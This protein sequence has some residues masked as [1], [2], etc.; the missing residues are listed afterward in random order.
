MQAVD[1][2]TT[3][4]FVSYMLMLGWWMLTYTMRILCCNGLVYLTYVLLTVQAVHGHV[5]W[6]R[7][8]AGYTGSS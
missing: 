8:F 3:R 7:Y 2:L 5:L 4:V 1:V 6:H